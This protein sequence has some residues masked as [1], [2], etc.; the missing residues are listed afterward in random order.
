MTVKAYGYVRGVESE[1]PST[2]E[3]CSIVASP[4]ELRRLSDFFL[5]V[6]EMMDKH[7]DDFGHE[8]LS[9]FAPEIVNDV[10]II[11]CARK[12]EK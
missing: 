3:E 7:G 2:L 4:I 12:N 11:L 10:D 8:H 6:A 1:E 5:K 9:D